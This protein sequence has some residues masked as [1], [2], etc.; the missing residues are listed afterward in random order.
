MIRL[1]VDATPLQKI[2]GG[3]GFYLFDILRSLIQQRRDIFFILY[4][5]K[6]EGELAEFSKSK[7]VQI[8]E[9]RCM[10]KYHA[11]WT[12]TGL[13]RQVWKDDLDYF[14]GITQF[15]PLIKRNKLS[16]ILTIHDFVYKLCPETMN[17][18]KQLFMK[19]LTPFFVSQSDFIFCISEGTK[20]KLKNFYKKKCADI[21]NPPIKTMISHKSKEECSKVIESF[22]LEYKKFLLTVGSI[23]PR[24]NIS[25]LLDFYENILSHHKIEDVLPLVIVGGGGWKNDEILN[26]IQKMKTKYPNHVKVLG[27]VPDDKI[28]FLYSSAKYFIL[29]SKYEGYGMPLAEARTCQTHVICFDQKEMREASEDDGI[30]LPESGFENIL[31]PLFLKGMPYTDLK[32]PC[33][34]MSTKDKALKLSSVIQ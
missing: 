12:Q 17:F 33:T 13:A 5:V 3:I 30:F 22:G 9:V 25:T 19:I 20:E 15:I 1:G 18:S 14:W 32:K 26:K 2:S 29:F 31:E 4:C 21:I 24:K 23:E 6:N 8:Q 10:S 11:I 28:S 16:T 27:F 7:N 34:Y